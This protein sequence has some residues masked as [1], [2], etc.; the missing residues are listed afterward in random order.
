MNCGICQ[1][2][3][4]VYCE[5]VNKDYD[6]GNPITGGR[7]ADEIKIRVDKFNLFLDSL[8]NNASIETLKAEIKG[9]LQIN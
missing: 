1:S 5:C 4:E 7:R 3:T 8:D 9:Y 2:F 6:D